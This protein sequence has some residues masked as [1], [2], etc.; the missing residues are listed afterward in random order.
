MSTREL[1]GAGVIQSSRTHLRGRPCPFPVL[2]GGPFDVDELVRTD[3]K[4]MVT[5][6]PSG[7]A[8]LPSCHG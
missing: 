1:P 6:T 3:N 7:S 5:L 2:G 8:L 4:A